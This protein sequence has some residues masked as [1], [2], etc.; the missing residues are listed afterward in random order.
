MTTYQV[1]FPFFF[2]FLIM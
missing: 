1:Q 2:A